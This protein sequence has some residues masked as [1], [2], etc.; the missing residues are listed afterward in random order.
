MGHPGIG[1]RPATANSVDTKKGPRNSHRSRTISYYRCV[2]IVSTVSL[3]SARRTLDLPTRASSLQL[4]R[5]FE[6]T[7]RPTSQPE[8]LVEHERFNLL[9]TVGGPHRGRSLLGPRKHRVEC[10]RAAVST[11]GRWR[12]QHSRW[13]MTE[14][15]WRPGS[16]RA[17]LSAGDPAALASSGCSAL[18]PWCLDFARRRGRAA[19]TTACHSGSGRRLA[20]AH[21]S[22]CA[23]RVHCAAVGVQPEPA[24]GSR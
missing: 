18:H 13:Q 4:T 8:K 24:G 20:V 7:P 14:T 2:L 19:A 10:L 15:H 3:I 5:S 21:N 9:H 16:K 22:D 11:G 1:E 23:Q 17:E 6:V 12:S